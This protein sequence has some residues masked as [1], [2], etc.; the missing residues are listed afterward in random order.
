MSTFTIRRATPQD[1]SAMAR[2]M[3]HPEVFGGLLQLPF[4][5]EA[6]WRQ[7]LESH[8]QDRYGEIHL[9]AEED[10]HLL[11]SAGLFSTEAC[12]RRRHVLS[13]GISVAP[14]AQGQGVGHKLMTALLDYADQWTGCL[15][16]ELTVFADNDRAIRLY[17]RHG[18]VREGRARGDAIRQGHLAD[19]LWMARYR[20]GG[21]LAPRVRT[22]DPAIVAQAKTFLAAREPRQAV[23]PVFAG[24]DDSLRLR[25]AV[26]QDAAQL[27]QLA[28][29]DAVYPHTV[30]LPHADAAAWQARLSHPGE[31]LD[32]DLRLVAEQ[33][34]QVLGCVSLTRSSAALRRRH[35]YTLTLVVAPCAHGHG[36]G[37]R[38]LEEA[39]HYA[40]HWLGCLRIELSVMADNVRA[41]QLYQHA[42]FVTEVHRR[43]DVLRAGQYVDGFVMARWHPEP[44]LWPGMS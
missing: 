14:Q 10:G 11:G 1:A 3:S 24:L 4:T 22:D 16:I 40:D 23:T 13:L 41:I 2:Y 7:R 26:P 18:F 25:R 38:L 32:G 43:G 30:G 34:G 6:I 35:A 28:A 19:S 9:V 12:V 37:R 39:L 17:E 20:P 29:D 44:P 5:D 15:R 36:L 33:G 8:V 31:P 27:A 21:N 42:G